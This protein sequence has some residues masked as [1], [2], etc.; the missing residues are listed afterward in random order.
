[1]NYCMIDGHRAWPAIASSI[2]VTLENPLLKD[3]DAQTMAIEFPLSVADNLALFGSVGRVEVRKST[4]TYDDCRLYTNNTLV[5]HGKGVVTSFTDTT[6]KLQIKAGYGATEIDEDWG[7]VYIDEIDAYGST[8]L[9]KDMPYPSDDNKILLKALGLGTVFNLPPVRDETNDKVCNTPYFKM[10]PTYSGGLKGDPTVSY[11]MS[12][13]Y[14]HRP[15]PQMYLN[16]C[17]RSVLRYMG[18]EPKGLLLDEE[19]WCRLL[20]YNARYTLFMHKALPHWSV[21]KLLTEVQNLFNLKF[22]FDYTAKTATMRRLEDITDTEAHECLDEFST[23]YDEEGVEYIGASNISYN[24]SDSECHTNSDIPEDTLTKFTVK[25]YDTL[26]DAQTAAPAMTVKERM[27]TVFHFKTASHGYNWGYC[28]KTTKLS[29]GETSYY[30]SPAFT[31]MHLRREEG[32]ESEVT[33]NLVP[34]AE[35]MVKMQVKG[36]YFDADSGKEL[37]SED[38]YFAAPTSTGDDD[39]D[40]DED[41]VEEE[42]GEA[43]YV[44]VQDYLEDAEEPNDDEEDERMELYFMTDKT[45]SYSFKFHGNTASGKILAAHTNPDEATFSFYGGEDTQQYIGQ[46]HLL[47]KAIDNK[48]QV[49]IKFLSQELPDPKHIFMFRGKRFICDKVELNITDQGLNPLMTGYFYEME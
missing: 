11:T 28:V 6:V 15:R 2:K 45:Y 16:H 33:L 35:G 23:D 49:I 9:A 14:L 12:G 4:L 5:I 22:V 38:F 17:V 46:L 37:N 18:F 10:I 1:M 7:E 36:Y 34:C 3:R 31:Y 27:T 43:D 25:E 48:V 19:P 44:S 26:S 24:L 47:K 21:K 20:I 39:G 41:D 30:I 40:A 13:P 29:D 32:T 42:S 8:G